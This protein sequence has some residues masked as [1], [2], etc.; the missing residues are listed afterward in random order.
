MVFKLGNFERERPPWLQ[1]EFKSHNSF[2]NQI[3]IEEKNF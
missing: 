2:L 1:N 3:K